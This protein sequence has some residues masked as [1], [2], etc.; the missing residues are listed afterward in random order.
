M[1]NIRS[2]FLI[3]LAFSFAWFAIPSN[4]VLA[5]QSFEPGIDR[6]GSDFHNFEI[7]QPPPGSLGGTVDICRDTCS[8]DGN[9]KAWTHVNPGVQGPKARCWLKNAI[10]GAVANGC[11]TSG[12]PMRALEPGIDRPQGD[13]NNFDLSAAD[14]GLCKQA[15]D[16]DGSRCQAWTFVNPQVQGPSARCWLK[17]SVPQAFTN[18]C[19]TSGVKFIGP[20]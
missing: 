3:C 7:N 5:N 9:C 6:P 19:C 2:T 20:N 13:Y 12:V 10:P 17:S 14:P 1:F 11:C 4:A 8:R 15:C 16:R 18:P